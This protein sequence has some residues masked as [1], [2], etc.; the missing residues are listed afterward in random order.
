MS[1][2]TVIATVESILVKMAGNTNFTTPVPPLVDIEGEK[3]DLKAAAALAK[4]GSTA[5]KA[6]VKVKLRIL[7]L[8]MKALRSYVEITANTG[9]PL[10]AEEVA[11]S[12]GMGVKKMTPRPKRVF[13]VMNTS[14][15]GSVKV[16]CATVK[17]ATAYDF[18]YTKTPADE[19]TYVSAGVKPSATRVVNDLPSV[20]EYW[21][22][23]CSISKTGRGAWSDPIKVVVA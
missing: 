5:Q 10:L 7:M 3:D 6:M 9:D 14:I 22:R 20:T 23:W 11:L 12:S 19:T 21:F 17:N 18:E 4:N 16:F 15:P 8:S 1:V 2:T 13:T